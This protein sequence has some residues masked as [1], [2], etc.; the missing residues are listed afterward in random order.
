MVNKYEEHMISKRGDVL[1]DGKIITVFRLRYRPA[2]R[3]YIFKHTREF[4]A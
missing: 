4:Y 3:F 2:R 1:I